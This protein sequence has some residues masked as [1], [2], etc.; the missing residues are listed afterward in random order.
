MVC[1]NI[2]IDYKAK[3]PVGGMRY[4]DGQKRCQNCDL[5]IHWEGI[6][7]PCC[8]TK[9]RAGPRRKGLKQMMVDSY[10]KPFQKLSK[11][12]VF[13]QKSVYNIVKLAVF[14]HVLMWG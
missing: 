12:S 6:R 8:S 13:G 7:C 4:L 5:F 2:C 14:T 3:K 11:T 1:K 10:R 9:L